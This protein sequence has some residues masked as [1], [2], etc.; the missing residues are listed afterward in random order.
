VALAVAATHC[1]AGCILCDFVAA[2][3]LPAFPFTLFGEGVFADWVVSFVFAF[4]FQYF[5][6]APRRH[7][8]A[9]QG[10]PAALKAHPLSLTAWQAGMYGWMALVSFVFFGHELPK[11]S[12]VFWFMMEIAMLAGFVTTYPVNWW[13]LRAGVKERM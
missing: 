10:L 1:G 5:T 11:T 13:L 7:L 9:G 8:S 12:P 2:G 4:A 6:I 3:L